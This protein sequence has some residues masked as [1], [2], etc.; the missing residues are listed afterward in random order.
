MRALEHRP[1][2]E[3]AR[4]RSWASS[5][6]G[7]W[8]RAVLVLALVVAA[9]QL[10]KRAVERSIVPGEERKLLPGVQLVDTRNHGIAFG[11]LPGSQLVV[12]LLIGVA[13]VA[14]LVY[15]ALHSR[16]ALIWLPTGMLVGGA[17]GNVVDRIRAG[18]VTDFIKLPLGWPPFNLADASITLGVITLFLVIEH[19]RHRRLHDDGP[20]RPDTILGAEPRDIE[21]R[22]DDAGEAEADRRA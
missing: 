9:D 11:V 20:D 4:G 16:E 13:L 17:A 7:P 12:T 6:T 21:G 2:R 1:R 10:S 15:F 3:H 18:S 19:A 8:G 22:R 5:L 14:L